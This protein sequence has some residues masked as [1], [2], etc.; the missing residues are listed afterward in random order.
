MCG[1]AGIIAPEGIRHD[2]LVRMS[3]ALQH[4]GPDGSGIML[5][6]RPTGLRLSLNEVRLTDQDAR[7][8]VGFAHRRLSIF[9]L[10]DASLQPMLD[11]RG[12]FCVTYNGELYNYLELKLEL[13]ALGY[14][15]RT[16]GDT[17]VLLRAYEAWGP[18]C[19]RR[20]NG[21]WAFAILDLRNDSVFLAR[22]RFGIKPLYW[23]THQGA[24][25]FASEIKGLLAVP[26]LRHQ[27][28]ER[29][30]ARY[31]ATGMVD[32]SIQTFF[33]GVEQ[34]PAAHWASI[35]LGSYTVEPT[36][37]RYW[38]IQHGAFAGSES[39]ATEQL[40]DLFLDAV[41]LHAQSDVPVGSCL[42]GGI[43]S[44]AI[45]CSAELLRASRQIP[46]YSHNAFG[47]CARDEQ[48]SEKR[49]MERVADHTS[50]R[51][52]YVDVS[53]RQVQQ[54]IPDVIRMQDEPFGSASIVAQWL[55]F[56]SAKAQ[57]MTVMLDGQGADETL[58][59]YHTYFATI[60]LDHL[61]H[62]RIA[63][64]RSLRAR[65]QAD[66]GPFPASH[67]ALMWSFAPA[68]VR[69]YTRLAKRQAVA[70]MRRL[71]PGDSAA[72]A[73]SGDLWSLYTRGSTENGHVPRALRDSLQASVE[74]AG[75]PSLLRFEDRNSMAHS[76]EAR[77]PFLDYR[78]VEFL[79]GLPDTWKVRDTRTKHL[80]REAMIGILPEPIRTRKDKIGFRADPA[81]TR[82]FVHQHRRTILNNSSELEQHWFSGEGL[83]TLLA[84]GKQGPA[85]E[86]AQWRVLN[87]KL[88]ARQHWGE[89]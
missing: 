45:V 33:D 59:G 88:W 4:R 17:E 75:L 24:C 14:T 19:L 13:E 28:N 3:A 65:F 71:V 55:V 50:A 12:L 29:V 52:H 18:D 46:H 63:D 41:R 53:D 81:W 73:I 5:Y 25:Y 56:Q 16:T 44:S 27:P 48:F 57:G 54:L 22:D 10:S 39:E 47:F 84:D 38:S 26:E 8:L 20:F 72:A 77:V 34:F 23:T 64:Y 42:S 9:D 61:A 69:E 15:F 67:R 66:I 87:T 68:S 31:L 7:D 60:A 51:M 83:E 32:D 37:R 43:D 36:P 79:F 86:L 76:I 70:S 30:V 1:I 21:M 49:Y 85:N 58:A 62:G 6:S 82:S 74:S 89:S 11:E 78:L 35:P 40:R 80:F 2:H